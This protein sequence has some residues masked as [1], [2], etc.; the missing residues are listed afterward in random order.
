MVCFAVW[1]F[2]GSPTTFIRSHAFSLL[3]YMSG[4]LASGRWLARWRNLYYMDKLPLGSPLQLFVACF[5]SWLPLTTFMSNGCGIVS[6]CFN[7]VQLFFGIFFTLFDI[8]TAL[9]FESLV[10][11][12]LGWRSFSALAAR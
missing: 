9:G 6:A 2:P 4:N 1:C 10:I 5:E 7:I 11:P 12:L 3:L 8:V